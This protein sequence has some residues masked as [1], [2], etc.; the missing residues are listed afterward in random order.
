MCNPPSAEGDGF[1]ERFFM[2]QAT[3]FPTYESIGIRPL[4]NC[5]GT[6]TNITFSRGVRKQ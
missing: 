5:Q 1:R 4:I 2:S 6:Y 3:E